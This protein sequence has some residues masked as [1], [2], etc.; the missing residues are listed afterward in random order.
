[1]RLVHICSAVAACILGSKYTQAQAHPGGSDFD[2]ITPL[3]LDAGLNY[4]FSGST[5]LS[6]RHV[7]LTGD[8]RDRRGRIVSKS[9]AA[10]PDNFVF[11]MDFKLEGEGRT[12][13]GDGMV[14][15]FTDEDPGM[16]VMMG[17]NEFY[18]GV[19]III[20]TYRNGRAGRIF[21]RMILAQ[22]DG[23]TP[24][25]ND[26]DGIANEIDSCG[27][28]GIHNNKRQEFS[29]IRVS[30]S[31]ALGKI[32]VDVDFRDKWETCAIAD[33]SLGP[34]SKISVSAATG[35]LTDGHIIKDLRL[36][37]HGASIP[38]EIVQSQ[39]KAAD[40]KLS[41]DG[42]ESGATFAGVIK[43]MFVLGFEFLLAVGIL[44]GGFCGWNEYKKY[45]RRREDDL[46]KLN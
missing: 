3:S 22:N 1:M 30:Y 8:A 35:E 41:R 13:Y 45:Q 33:V 7:T 40:E 11:T 10:L 12:L 31:R 28:R 9:D 34:L 6:R 26:N 38:A 32:V 23:S 24:Y 5:V 4:G 20:D 46:Y 14:L 25:D 37:D 21:P 43:S 19:A 39:S 36:V 16:G 44:W 42:I 17:S 29:K 27:L 18:K 15:T 2:L